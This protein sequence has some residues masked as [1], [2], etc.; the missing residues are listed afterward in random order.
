MRLLFLNPAALPLLAAALVPLIVHLLVKRAARRV[1]FPTLRFVPAGESRAARINRVSDG[2]LLALRTLIIATVAAALARPL[3]ITP[4]R[5]RAWGRRMSRLIVVDVSESARRSLQN[6]RAIAGEQAGTSAFSEIVETASVARTL[7]GAA[8]RLARFPPSRREIVVISDFQEG[9]I[10]EASLRHLE[11]G[12]GVRLLS[13]HS[14][15][16]VL[17]PFAPRLPTILVR[18]GQQDAARRAL[19][20]VAAAN[21]AT[22]D[23]RD[24]RVVVAVRGAPGVE[25]LTRGA[26]AVNRPWMAEVVHRIAN[27]ADIEVVAAGDRLVI[28]T[29]S[30]PESFAFPALLDA[31]YRGLSSEHAALE[32]FVPA[33]NAREL[34]ALERDASG[35]PPDAVRH[36][37]VHDARWFWIGAGVLLGLEQWWR[38]RRVR[39]EVAE[40]MAA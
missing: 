15:G 12:T 11:Q 17:P 39:R 36:S 25:E 31:V 19:R 1:L 30:S 29:G 8:D 32:A 10:D 14:V 20:A 18:R 38:A 35:V 4:S 7:P 26:V 33:D 5:E 6:A 22:A 28:V 27:S 23:R 3:L 37:T 9:T 13:V 34:A 21:G 2:V 16:P 40:R 24:E